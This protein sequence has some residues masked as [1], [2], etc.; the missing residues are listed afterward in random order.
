MADLKS[1]LIV[2]DPYPPYQYLGDGRMLGLDHDLVVN[3]FKSVG[4]YVRIELH[5]WDECIRL[6]DNGTADAVFQMVRTPEREEKYLFSDLLRK[7]TIMLYRSKS[8]NFRLRG[9]SEIEDQLQGYRLGLVKGYS[10]GPQID[11]LR[12]VVKIEVEDQEG[13]LNGLVNGSF[14][15]AL[16]DRGV[17]VYLMDRLGLKGKLEEVEGFKITRD[18]YVAF[19]RDKEALLTSFNMGLKKIRLNGMYQRIFRKYGIQP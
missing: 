9:D 10:Y 6:L 1:P 8:F 5:P 12:G 4:V 11:G 2:A 15:L 17:S 14:D 7:A 18:L 16:I 19:R 13:L 3:A